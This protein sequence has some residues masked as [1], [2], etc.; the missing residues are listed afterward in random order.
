MVLGWLGAK[1]PNLPQEGRLQIL[2]QASQKPGCSYRGL[3]RMGQDEERPARRVIGLALKAEKAQKHVSQA[4]VDRAAAAGLELRL[5]DS[6]RP[7]EEQGPFDV[8]LQKIGGSGE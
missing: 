4:L 1:R 2:Q 8:L 5:V 3:L 6:A 7:L